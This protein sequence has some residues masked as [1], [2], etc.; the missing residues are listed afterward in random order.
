[1]V[2]NSIS[3][4]IALECPLKLYLRQAKMNLA[5]V[6]GHS[7]WVA[8]ELCNCITSMCFV[9]LGVPVCRKYT[10]TYLGSRY[11]MSANHSQKV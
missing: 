9:Y 1:M 7:D 5:L 6:G 11:M 8:R 2:N 4:F 3:N 10:L